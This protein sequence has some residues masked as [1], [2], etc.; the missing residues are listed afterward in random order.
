MNR[1]GT[2]GDLHSLSFVASARY[3]GRPSASSYAVALQ[4]CVY[5]YMCIVY[6]VIIVFVRYSVFSTAI[7]R[8]L[9]PHWILDYTEDTEK[10]SDGEL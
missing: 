10:I 1:G 3:A 8:S 6:G 2:H 5:V 9:Y 4:Y 7:P